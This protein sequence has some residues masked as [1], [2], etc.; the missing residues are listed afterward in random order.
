MRIDII[1]LWTQP[2]TAELESVQTILSPIKHI[3]TKLDKSRH[4][5]SASK[6]FQW[7]IF[8]LIIC[9]TFQIIVKIVSNVFINGYAIGVF[10]RIEGFIGEHI[11]SFIYKRHGAQNIKSDVFLK[12]FI[13]FFWI[14]FTD[15]FVILLFV[16]RSW[17]GNLII[18]WISIVVIY[19]RNIKIKKV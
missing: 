4:F 17:I 12:W 16:D 18:I 15:I 3:L 13:S 6:H 5:P 1:N 2:W 9:H 14:I 19:W 7:M 11:F 8:T 10:Y